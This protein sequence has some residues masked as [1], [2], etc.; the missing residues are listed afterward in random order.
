MIRGFGPSLLIFIDFNADNDADVNDE[1]CT[2][3][4]ISGD[5][6]HVTRPYLDQNICLLLYLH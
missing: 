4:K 3:T 2:I 1:F 5:D 6:I